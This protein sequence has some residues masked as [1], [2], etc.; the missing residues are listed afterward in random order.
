MAEVEDY[1]SCEICY[2]PYDQNNQQ[3]LPKYTSGCYHTFCLSCLLDIYTRNDHTFKCPYC[4]KSTKKNPREFKT[5]SKIFSHYLICCHCQNKVPPDKLFLSLYN[6]NMEIKCTKCHGDNDY[7]LIEYL[8]ALLNELRIFYE[9]YKANKNFNLI[10]FVKEKI[11]KQIENYMQDVIGKM[12]DL[13][14]KNI[15]NQLKEIINYDLEKENNEFDKKLQKT[16]FDYK[17]LNEFYN[18][19]PAKNFDSKKILE[20]LKYY[21]D[22]IDSLKKDK[23]KFDRIKN[24]V[25]GK[26]LFKLKDNFDK[27]KLYNF[28]MNNFR[29]ILSSDLPNANN[30]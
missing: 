30:F 2:E 21:D 4:R 3:K 9:Y 10:D 18:N 27:E 13:M 24:D 23:N 8:P 16:V 6:G 15:I 5:N 25:E 22:N 28:L 26:N 12:A 17:Y 7:Q 1:Y 20:I 29:T 14:T 19:E 11:K